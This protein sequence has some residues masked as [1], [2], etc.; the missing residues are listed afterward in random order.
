MSSADNMIAV[1]PRQLADML[2]VAIPSGIPTVI[3]GEPGLGKTEI[4]KQVF[5]TLLNTVWQQTGADN[6]IL[7]PVS[8]EPSDYKGLPF[9]TA[10]G[11]DFSIYGNMRLLTRATRPLLVFFDDIGQS[12]NAVQASLMQV[13]QGKQINNNK[14]SPFVYFLGA[15]NDRGAGMAVSGLL[16]PLK[17]RATM[18]YLQP[19]L[20]DWSLWGAANGIDHRIISFLNSNKQK[21][22]LFSDPRSST[23]DMSA[24]ASPRNWQRVS[25]HMQLPY[26]ADVRTAVYAGCVG[27]DTA[28]RFCAWLDI[29]D[30]VI[31]A[32]VVW[33]NPTGCTIP[34]ES[35]QLWAL[36][37]TLANDVSPRTVK[38]FCQFLLRLIDQRNEY[39]ALATKL[40]SN[41]EPTLLENADWI[42]Y[43]ATSAIGKLMLTA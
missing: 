2:T 25:V 43:G 22:E 27:K 39:V 8:D 28:I 10:D 33:N 24:K 23:N 34:S 36:T 4:E 21:P 31:P 18:M 6:L 35:S 26:R 40:M 38:P 16:E 1:K 42:K 20:L 12:L 7:H 30:K 3:V 29:L 13:W 19:D 41:R 9:M 14:I 11:A 15:T 37:C 32:A 5:N 17:G